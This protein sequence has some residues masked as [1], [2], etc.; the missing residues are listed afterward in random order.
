[1]HFG[2]AEE[3]EMQIERYKEK[4]DRLKQ[5]RLFKIWRGEF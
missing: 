2:R 4:Y 5:V 1:M 3:F